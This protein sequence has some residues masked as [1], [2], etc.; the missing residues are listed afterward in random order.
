MTQ[1]EDK[2]LEGYTLDT[3][4]LEDDDDAG[5]DLDDEDDMDDDDIMDITDADDDD[6][7]DEEDDD[8]SMD[9]EDEELDEAFGNFETAKVNLFETFVTSAVDSER[10]EE[11][12][13]ELKSIMLVA[14]S[15]RERMFAKAAK[16]EPSF[17]SLNFR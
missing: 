2:E 5:V 8:V 1:Y 15:D 17:S 10:I 6:F 16:G 12:I 9:D 14:P 3:E 13:N 7:D 4:D 11:R